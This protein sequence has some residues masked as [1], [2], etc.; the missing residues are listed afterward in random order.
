MFFNHLC[1]HGLMISSG[2]DFLS[3]PYKNVTGDTFKCPALVKVCIAA[4]AKREETSLFLQI[5]FALAML[6]QAVR[7][8]TPAQPVTRHQLG[9]GKFLA[10]AIL[11]L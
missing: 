7:R 4:V 8:R 6:C 3:W 11:K 5:R 1:T 9:S 2:L 10:I